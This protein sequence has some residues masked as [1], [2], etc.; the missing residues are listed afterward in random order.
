[1]LQS[2]RFDYVNPVGLLDIPMVHRE[3]KS[4]YLL[5]MV[6]FVYHAETVRGVIGLAACYLDRPYD[7]YYLIRNADAWSRELDFGLFLRP[8]SARRQL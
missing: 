5:R 7:R 2:F 1:M 6:T 4:S 3:D 8:G